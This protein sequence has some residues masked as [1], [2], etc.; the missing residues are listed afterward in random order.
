MKWKWKFITVIVLLLGTSLIIGACSTGGKTNENGM[1]P[2]IGS[3]GAPAATGDGRLDLKWFVHSEANAVLAQGDEDFVKKA[4]QDKFNVNLD[5]QYMP[6]GPDFE[7]KL[8]MRIAA[9]DIPDLFVSTGIASQTYIRDGVTADMT[10]YVTPQTMPNYFKLISETELKR[11]AVENKFERAPL[12]FPRQV[13][14]SYYVRKD[15]LDKLGLKVPETYDD[16]MNVM[17]AFTN[18]DPDGNGKKDT[19]GFSAAGNGQSI[20]WD[21]PQWNMHGLGGAFLIV[22]NKLVDS[23]SDPKVEQVIQGIK[24]MM[25]EGIVDPDWFLNKGTQHV[26]KA[27]QGKVGIIVG[28]SKNF[29][30]DS[31]P[32]SLQNRTR[33]IHPQADWAAFHPAAKEGT[34]SENLPEMPFMFGKNTSPDKIKR[35]VEILDWLSSEEGFLLTNYGIEGKHYTKEGN[36]IKPIPEAVQKDIIESGNLLGVYR[37]FVTHNGE[38]EQFGLEL[39]DPRYTDRD[40]A[41]IKQIQEYKLNGSIGTNVSPPEGFNLADFRK[42]MREYQ[43]SILFDEEDASN[44][45]KYREELMNDHGGQQMLDVYTEQIKAAGVIK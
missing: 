32:L 33:A 25:K 21:F 1:S 39:A 43:I 20:S 29:A 41:I 17:R 4:I 27:A 30:L 31:D 19:F 15:W 36:Q 11:Y 45:P 10:P 7:N 22:D 18:E 38:P 16:M 42:K 2:E 40:K 24:D 13:Y 5:I 14:R 12:I 3:S 37:F 34:W 8:N 35:M 23:Q 44:W 28:G 6:I 9:G 26:D